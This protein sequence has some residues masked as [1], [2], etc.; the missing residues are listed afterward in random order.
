VND[1]YLRAPDYEFPLG[2]IQM[3]GK[4]KGP[5]FREDSHGFAPGWTLDQMAKHAVDF[6]LTG[7]DLG[8]RKTA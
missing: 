4:S 2:N 8:C 7:E 5:M 1:F 6:W 3:I